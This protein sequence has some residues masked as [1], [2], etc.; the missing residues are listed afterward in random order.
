MKALVSRAKKYGEV[1]NEIEVMDWFIH[2]TRVLHHMHAQLVPHTLK[3]YHSPYVSH[4]LL[5]P[6]HSP[7]VAHFY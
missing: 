3:P 6:Y 4:L 1:L 2:M 7:Y 5:K